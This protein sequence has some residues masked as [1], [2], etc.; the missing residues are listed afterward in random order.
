[1]G[2]FTTRGG[3]G[4][5]EV[6]GV[7]E[8]NFPRSEHTNKSVKWGQ[9]TRGGGHEAAKQSPECAARVDEQ[10]DSRENIIRILNQFYAPTATAQ[11]PP[12]GAHEARK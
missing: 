2:N 12:C 9:T 8:S 5:G 7:D 10:Q 11:A 3:A 6:A 1:M 4:E